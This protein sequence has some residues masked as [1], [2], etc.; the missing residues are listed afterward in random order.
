MFGY[1]GNSVIEVKICSV[2]EVICS[3]IEMFGYQKQLFGISIT[4][5][6]VIEV[7]LYYL[8]GKLLRIFL[9]FLHD[10]IVHAARRESLACFCGIKDIAGGVTTTPEIFK[11]KTY[12]KILL[13][14]E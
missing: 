5:R 8:F 13:H 1:R 12:S 9:Y 3:V 14:I 11:L 7:L 6:S 4:E 2:I 10:L